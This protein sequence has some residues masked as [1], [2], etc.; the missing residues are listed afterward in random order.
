[1]VGI[2]KAEGRGE[3]IKLGPIE[4]ALP[5]VTRHSVVRSA[6]GLTKNCTEVLVRPETRKML[7]A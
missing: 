3:Q 7:R 4:R 5:A 6:R 1:V 2:C